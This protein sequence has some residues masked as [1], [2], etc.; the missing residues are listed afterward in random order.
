MSNR[1]SRLLRAYNACQNLDPDP[2]PT[3]HGSAAAL[4][5][6]GRLEMQRDL[7]RM[8]VIRTTYTCQGWRR[9]ARRDA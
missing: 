6:R 5:A 8:G 2:L 7:L 9:E 4:L 3:P 1:V